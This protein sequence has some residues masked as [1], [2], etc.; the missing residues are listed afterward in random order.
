METR[1]VKDLKAGDMIDLQGD[2]IADAPRSP[3]SHWSSFEFE[4]ALVGAVI[5]ETPNCVILFI[6]GDDR[7]GFP[8]DHVVP[9]AGHDDEYVQES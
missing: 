6:D 3:D 8:P 1:M 4:Y 9:Y 2:P 5:H 7:Y